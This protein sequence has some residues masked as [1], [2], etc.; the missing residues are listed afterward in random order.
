MLN[1][2]CL[3]EDYF[4][5]IADRVYSEICKEMGADEGCNRD[6]VAA[7][8]SIASLTLALVSDGMDM[9]VSALLEAGDEDELEE[10][11]VDAL[12]DSLKPGLVRFSLVYD[13]LDRLGLSPAV[14]DYEGGSVEFGS[15]PPEMQQRV[16][17]AVGMTVD[18]V[19]H[20]GTRVSA[21]AIDSSTGEPVPFEDVTPEMLEHSRVP[22]FVFRGR[23]AIEKREPISA[24]QMID[25]FSDTKK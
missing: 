14:P 20:S 6:L 9:A 2:D 5:D 11:A 24:D 18:E 22:G 19:L 15:L 17:D 25:F 23:G 3:P 7:F 21:L 1:M 4:G 13:S 12:V 16:A 10:M 8:T